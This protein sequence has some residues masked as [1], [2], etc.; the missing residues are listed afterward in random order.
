VGLT[1]TQSK[2]WQNQFVLLRRLRR[3]FRE[4]RL[5]RAEVVRRGVVSRTRLTLILNDNL[6]GVSSEMLIQLLQSP[7]YRVIIP[8]SCADMAK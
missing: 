6:D 4:N 3:F 5:T 1:E 7:G 8:V 2:E